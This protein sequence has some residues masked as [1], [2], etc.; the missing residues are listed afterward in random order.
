MVLYI[1]FFFA[2]LFACAV[3]VG[4]RWRLMEAVNHYASHFCGRK[5]IADAASAVVKRMLKLCLMNT[6][7]SRGKKLSSHLIGGECCW[8]DPAQAHDFQT[9]THTR[10]RNEYVFSLILAATS[11]HTVTLLTQSPFIFAHRWV[12]HYSYKSAHLLFT[13]HRH[14]IHSIRTAATN[15]ILYDVFGN[16]CIMASR[17]RSESETNY[18]G[19]RRKWCVILFDGWVMRNAEIYISSNKPN[20]N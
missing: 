13:T 11:D 19:W 14:S 6:A 15:V 2:R 5:D 12:C 7:E 20:L 18:V 17:A 4:S 10:C 1:N 16:L 9:H 3:C 8:I